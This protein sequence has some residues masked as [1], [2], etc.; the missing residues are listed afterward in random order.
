MPTVDSVV[1][2]YIKL[3]DHK[4]AIK[5]RHQ[6]ELAPIK[7]NMDVMENWLHKQ[8]LEQGAQNVKTKFGTAYRKK[9]VS[10]K[11]EDFEVTLDFIKEWELWDLLEARV[12]KTAVEDWMETHDK[13]VPPGVSYSET[14]VVQVR[15]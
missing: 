11:V 13:Q 8:M 2:A 6:E 15:R 1:A 3:R 9:V 7:Q 5:A 10:I 4:D 14:E 12:S